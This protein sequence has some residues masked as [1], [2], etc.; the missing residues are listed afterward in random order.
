MTKLEAALLIAIIG[1][2]GAIAVSAI[3]LAGARWRRFDAER[4][5]WRGL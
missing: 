2:V 5:K 4:G 1:V 3:N